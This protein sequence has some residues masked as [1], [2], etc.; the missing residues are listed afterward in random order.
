M[1]SVLQICSSLLL[2]AALV[3]G[4]SSTVTSLAP[5][6]QTV[7]PSSAAGVPLNSAE[8]VQLTTEVLQN[9]TTQLNETTVSYFDFGNDS[10]TTTSRRSTSGCKVFPGDK[11]WPIDLIWDILDLL[12]GGRLIKTVPSASSCYSNWG[13][14]SASECSYVN[15]E[16][17]D[18][19]FQLVFPCICLPT[20]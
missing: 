7:S 14:E 12:L 19:H 8:T 11:L 18:S 9:L 13:D 10:T 2:G 3:Q 1:A 4:Q 5:A 17:T 16:W 20:K 15:S 6:A